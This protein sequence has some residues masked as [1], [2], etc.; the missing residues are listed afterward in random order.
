MTG[1]KTNVVTAIIIDGPNTPDCPQFRPLVEAT[2][3]NF[4]VK[5]VSADKAYLSHENLEQIHRL[6]GTAF[7]PFKTNSVAGEAGTLWERAFNYFQFKRED[8]LKFYHKRS[9]VETTF[10][11]VKAKFG[12]S[13]RSRSDVAMKN[14]VLL[15]FL[16]HNI[17]CLI[18]AQHELGIEPIFWGDEPMKA[19][20]VQESVAV[21]AIEP[22]RVMDFGLDDFRFSD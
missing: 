7:I 4:T 9:L 11:M 14:E 16:C 19:E 22:M 21:A 17:C 15:K 13:V 18:M 8:F 5:E 1:T 12:D 10:S 3:K 2:A 6:G 20:A